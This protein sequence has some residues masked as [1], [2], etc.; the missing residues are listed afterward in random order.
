ML[1]WHLC[2]RQ[3]LVLTDVSLITNYWK[4]FHQSICREFTRTVG[5]FLKFI[6]SLVLYTGG[7][8]K[9]I[10]LFYLVIIMFFFWFVLSLITFSWIILLLLLFFC[11]TYFTNSY[12]TECMFYLDWRHVWIVIILNPATAVTLSR[13][14]VKHGSNA[15]NQ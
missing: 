1:G 11:C 7:F 3:C 8:I 12:L 13:W 5:Y 6:L 4:H 15:N 2:Q 10:Q 9:Q 14:W